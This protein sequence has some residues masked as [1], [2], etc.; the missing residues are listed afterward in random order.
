MHKYLF[1]LV[2]FLTLFSLTPSLVA[3]SP[4]FGFSVNLDT[5]YQQPNLVNFKR[6]IDRLVENNQTYLRTSFYEWS[7]VTNQGSSA[8][9]INWNQGNLAIYEQALQYAKQKNLKIILV[10]NT[11]TYASSYS[12]ID[13]ENVTR[14]YYQYLAGRFGTMVDIWQVFNEANSHSFKDYSNISDYDAAYLNRLN[15]LIGLAKTQIKATSPSALITTN[16]AGLPQNDTAIDQTWVRYFSGL[17]NIDILG[18]DI[19]TGNFVDGINYMPYALGRLAQAVNKP[20][21]IAEVGHCTNSTWG[22]QAMYLPMLINKLKTVNLHSLIVYQYQD[23]SITSTDACERSFGIEDIA[24]NS[25]EGY[26]PVMQAMQNVFTGDLDNDGQ[27]N[28]FDYNQL[29]ANFGNPYSIYDYNILVATL[30]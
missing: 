1:L 13:Y 14:M 10:T 23:Q 29:V 5:G 27:V 4:G 26:I 17:S 7:I 15:E 11:P 22:S 18:P 21:M 3:A 8:Q 20:I 28:I 6:S 16:A 30:M 12:D 2:L 24:G 25:K 9:S 19:Y